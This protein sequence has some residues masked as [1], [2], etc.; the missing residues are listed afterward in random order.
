VHE[1]FD[2]QTSFGCNE[3]LI[4]AMRSWRDLNCI[5]LGRGKE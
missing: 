3:I 5:G 4:K 1:F 2:L